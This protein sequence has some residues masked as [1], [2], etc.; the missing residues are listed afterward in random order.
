MPVVLVPGIA[1]V[2]GVLEALSI[3]VEVRAVRP[4]TV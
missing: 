2:N 3:F 4:R 1:A